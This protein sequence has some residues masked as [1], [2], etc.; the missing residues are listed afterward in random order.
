MIQEAVYYSRMVLGIRQLLR[1]PVVA[2]PL[3]ALRW[4]LEHREEHFLCL[5]RRIVFSNPRHPYCEMFRMAGCSA[6]DLASEVGGNGLE[7]T[8]E[9][10]YEAGVYL[11]HDEFKGKTPLVRSGREIP[12]RPKTLLNP[13]VR[14]GTVHQLRAAHRAEPEAIRTTG[15]QTSASAWGSSST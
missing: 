12:C 5:A 4:N 8:L 13:L 14:G 7:R 2:D 10:L 9:K 11:T 6:E 1:Q 3:A 15:L